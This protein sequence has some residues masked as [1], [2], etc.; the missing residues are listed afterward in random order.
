M[1][2]LVLP[3]PFLWKD[4]SDPM[5]RFAAPVAILILLYQALLIGFF[6]FVLLPGHIR[7]F[8]FEDPTVDVDA[9]ILRVQIFGAIYTTAS[10]W[11]CWPLVRSFRP[12]RLTARSIGVCMLL[13]GL[14]LAASLFRGNSFAAVG[15]AT[16]LLLIALCYP[17][18]R[19]RGVSRE[20]AARGEWS[21]SR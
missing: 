15:T 11:M 8:S 9:S 1:G 19:R 2:S 16:A 7:A 12:G 6:C 17:N 21:V 20:D 3:T 13:E 10:I 4:G 18:A 14:L 5:H